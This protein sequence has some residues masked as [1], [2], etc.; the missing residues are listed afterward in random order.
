L[1]RIHSIRGLEHEVSI[2][3]TK[4]GC[5]SFT[6]WQRS[7][8]AEGFPSL[9]SFPAYDIHCGKRGWESTST[10]ALVFLGLIP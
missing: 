4:L 5:F 2:R 9:N 10:T 6:I 3:N 7:R 1:A 8:T